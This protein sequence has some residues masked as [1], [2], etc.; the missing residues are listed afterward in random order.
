[1]Q[2]ERWEKIQQLY[3]AA[4]SQVPE[5]RTDF[6]ARACAD[7][8]SLQKE[9]ESLII[10]PVSQRQFVPGTHTCFRRLERS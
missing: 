5:F 10:K 6:L 4:L 8:P 7:E 9:V 3:H 2:A 1:M